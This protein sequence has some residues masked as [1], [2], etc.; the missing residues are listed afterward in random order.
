MKG[1]VRVAINSLLSFLLV[2]TFLWGGCVSCEQFFMFPGSRQPCCNKAGQCERPTKNAPAAP[3]QDCNRMP[4]AV[5][6]NNHVQPELLAVMPIMVGPEA[7]Q[8]L[9]AACFRVA[10]REVL[11]EHSPPELHV[12]NSTFLI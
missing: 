10:T 5:S 4:L 12:L 9:P 7:I 8:R 6:G 2:A 11:L 3:K 1:V